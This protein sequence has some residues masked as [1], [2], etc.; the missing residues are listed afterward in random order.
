MG[1]DSSRLTNVNEETENMERTREIS[2]MDNVIR[3][4]VRSGVQHNM[5]VILRGERG[6]GKTMLW[7]RFQGMQYSEKVIIL[8]KRSF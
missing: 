3:Q 7:K 8:L 4:R 1:A 6:T 5:K 2:R